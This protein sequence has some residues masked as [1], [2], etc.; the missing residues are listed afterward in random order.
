VLQ[1]PADGSMTRL[2]IGYS[3][4]LFHGDD[5]VLLFQ[6]AYDPV[7]GIE[8][9]LLLHHRLVAACRY[10]CR[11][12]A[13]VGY[14]SARESRRLFGQEGDVK[15]LLQLD[16]AKVH[17]ED[18]LSLLQVG[19]LHVYLA[20]EAAGTEQRLVEYVSPVCGSEDDHSA[21]GAKA[22]H[23]R[24]QLVEGVLPLVIGAHI[25]VAAPGTP[26]GID[27]IYE[28]YAR[29]LLLGLLEEIPHARGADA[30]EHLD[31]V[32]SRDGE[33]W[34]V[35]LSCHSLGE[36]RLAGPRGSHEQCPLGDLAP[37][38]GVLL[39][40]LEEVNNLHHLG[41]G[42]LK[43]CHIIEVNLDMR[44]LVK[45]LRLRFAYAEDVAGTAAC[46][47]ACHPPHEVYPEGCDDQEWQ[48]D[49]QEGG[50]IVFSLLVFE[51]NALILGVARLLLGLCKK[52]LK[53]LYRAEGMIVMG[54]GRLESEASLLC[55]IRVSPALQR[56]SIKVNLSLLL[57]D[58]DH[59]LDVAVHHHLLNLPL[60][61]LLGIFPGEKYIYYD[62]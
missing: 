9:V 7:D 41:L 62:E 50:E 53:E 31:E 61:S 56:V 29:G 58:H 17:L 30:D 26:Y 20:V 16:R 12:I 1:E 4:L 40:V 47:A 11:L 27:L 3:P 39:R 24:E 35:S 32:G 38:R 33:E 14:V 10:Q 28:Y 37:Q 43:P 57:I 23:L 22:V 55:K 48:Y 60:V 44:V 15:S 59:L 52:L 19:E 45:D 2:M 51:I 18:S 8:E 42:L 46:T 36:Q 49:S 6:A 21:V 34:Y 25:R 54:L 13:Y 5:L